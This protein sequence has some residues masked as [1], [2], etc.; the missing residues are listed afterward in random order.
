MAIME[1]KDKRRL[2]AK[3]KSKK[4]RSGKRR[5]VSLKQNGQESIERKCE[6]WS[7]CCVVSQVEEASS[8]DG[9]HQLRYDSD[10]RINR[11]SFA[12][13]A[14]GSRKEK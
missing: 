1:T 2:F 6:A 5:S 9:E 3:G 10:T 4:A 13:P 14:V 11:P 7:R 12:H 8:V